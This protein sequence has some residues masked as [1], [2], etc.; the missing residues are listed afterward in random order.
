MKLEPHDR[1]EIGS[2]RT[3][4]IVGG[5]AS[6]SLVAIQLLKRA[7]WPSRIIVVEPRTELGAGIPY[8]TAYISHLL[9]VPAEGM[10]AF[11]D[12]PQHFLRWLRQTNSEQV[13]SN[14]F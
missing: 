11:E 13:E 7:A 9:N 2:Q 8:S 10:S 4:V 5:G 1:S 14:A 3:I 6:G 12:D